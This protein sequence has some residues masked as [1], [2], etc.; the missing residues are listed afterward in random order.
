MKPKKDK[1]KKKKETDVEAAST[2]TAPTWKPGTMDLLILEPII[3]PH[4]DTHWLCVSDRLAKNK[5]M[6]VYMFSG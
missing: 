6:C 3:G 1:T 2:P 5:D 4:R